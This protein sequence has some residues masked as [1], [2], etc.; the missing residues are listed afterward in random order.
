MRIP[1]DRIH[2]RWHPG[3]DPVGTVRPGEEVTLET[4]DGL[5]G[6]LT[7]ESTHADAGTL[8][9]GLGHPLTG[10][11]FVEGA[12]PGDL[13]EVELVAYESDDFGA[14]SV[15]PGFGFLADLFTDPFLVKWQIAG[16]IARSA[17]L[18]GIAVPGDPFAGVIGVAPSAERLEEFRAREDAIRAAGGPVADELPESAEPPAAATGLRTIP[19][20]ETGGNLDVRH[21]VAGSTL[22]LPVEVPGALFSA[23]DLHFAQGDG[24]V[25]GTAIEIAGAVTVRFG[26]RKEPSW[27]PAFPAYT[28]PARPGR[29]CF[30]TTGLPVHDAMDLTEATRQALLELI[31]W[32][33]SEHGFARPAAYALCSACA[34]LRL[35]ELVDVPYPLRVGAA[36][37]RRVRVRLGSERSDPQHNPMWVA[38]PFWGCTSRVPSAEDLLVRAATFLAFLGGLVLLLGSVGLAVRDR[39]DKRSATDRALLSKVGD[40]AGQVEEYFA[41]ARAINLITAHNPVFH[42]FYAAPRE[43]GCQGEGARPYHPRCGGRPRISRA[44][45]SDEHRRGLLHRPGRPGKCPLRGRDASSLCGSVPGR[46]REPVLRADVRAA[47][48][49]GLP[50]EAVRLAGHEESG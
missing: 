21:L 45:L 8:D 30:A 37:A 39:S 26:L 50:G 5:A 6:Q 3:L 1:A 4:L 35:S 34:D 29:V 38:A 40:E 11:V 17:E 19:P 18:P 33:E 23:G 43:P 10:P 15:I 48:R 20:R 14:T 28:T 22:L 27:R 25:C 16:G 42:D 7:R 9:L 49:A 31:G 44:A 46:E 12:E 36:P 41:R 13:L 32:L 24:E 47:R 2:N